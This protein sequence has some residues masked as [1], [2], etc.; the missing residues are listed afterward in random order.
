LLFPTSCC[1]SSQANS[2]KHDASCTST[3]RQS[4]SGWMHTPPARGSQRMSQDGYMEQQQLQQQQVRRK[5]MIWAAYIVELHTMLNEA[6]RLLQCALTY[7]S[8]MS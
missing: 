7:Y 6:D 5:D 8:T 2:S 1:S 3:A 4:F